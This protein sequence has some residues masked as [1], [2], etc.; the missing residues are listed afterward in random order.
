[1]VK[2]AH[3][4]SQK[5]LFSP[6]S[7]RKFQGFLELLCLEQ[8]MKIKYIFLVI[9]QY[10][11]VW[12]LSPGPRAGKEYGRFTL[13]RTLLLQLSWGCA[14]SAPCLGLASSPPAPS[15]VFPPHTLNPTHHQRGLVLTFHPH[16]SVTQL[17]AR[18]SAGCRTAPNPSWDQ[19]S[20]CT[21]FG[22]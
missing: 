4:E 1:M 10:H 5:M 15:P 12:G 19:Q 2:R 11:S 6:L 7:L 14:W 9:S 16:R 8:G 13:S 18:H 22:C 3:Y 17:Y 20:L 21:S